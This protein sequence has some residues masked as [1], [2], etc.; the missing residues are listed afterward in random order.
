MGTIPL[1]F[2]LSST[3]FSGLPQDTQQRTE[4]LLTAAQSLFAVS[5]LISLRLTATGA[6]TLFVLFAV[7]FAGSILLPADVD[8]VLVLVLS[9]LYVVL[10]LAPFARHARTT[11]RLAR[12]GTVTP[13]A[14]LEPVTS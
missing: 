11:R 1:A 14:D 10:A 6:A 7:Q 3:S 13:F 12:D 5:L 9:A 4:L 8:R 2:A